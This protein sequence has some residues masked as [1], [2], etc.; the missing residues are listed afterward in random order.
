MSTLNITLKNNIPQNARLFIDGKEYTPV[1]EKNATLSVTAEVG[2][3]AEVKIINPF[4]GQLPFGKWFLRTV[5]YW[6]I[7]VFGIFD[8]L[9]DVNKHCDVI[10]YLGTFNTESDLSLTI[11]FN[12]FKENGRVLEVIEGAEPQTE[13]ANGYSTDKVAKKRKVWYN[14]ARVISVIAFALV[15]G[16][17]VIVN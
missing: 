8:F 2:N 16:F 5:F 1:R 3:S 9:T 14:V 6:L 17:V 4:E 13:S 7:S 10:E 12:R 15:L 11:K